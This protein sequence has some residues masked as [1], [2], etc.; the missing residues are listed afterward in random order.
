MRDAP[1]TPG[2]RHAEP[3]R[4]CTA[5]G[6]SIEFTGVTKRY[7]PTTAVEN[8]DLSVRS[9]EFLTLLGPSGSGKST[10]L[11][12]LAGFERPTS[13]DIVVSGRKMNDVPAHRRDQGVV[14]QSYA[15]FPHMSVSENLAY[16]LAARGIAGSERSRLINRALERVR[17]SG[18]D[19]RLPSQLSGGQQQ[20]VA[21]A[22]A[23]VHDPPILLM[24]ESLSALDRNLREEMQIELKDLHEQLGNTIVYVT[25][26]QGEA[27]TMSDRVAVLSQGRLVQLGTPDEVYGSPANAFVAGFIGDANLIPGKALSQAGRLVTVAIAAGQALAVETEETVEAGQELLLMIRPESILLQQMASAPRGS[28]KIGI[29]QGTVKT[30]IFMGD[31]HRY[32]VE[33]LDLKLTTKALYSPRQRKFGVGETVEIIIPSERVRLIDSRSDPVDSRATHSEEKKTR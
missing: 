13:G 29:L 11:M 18:F 22:R 27:L 23:I 20:R 9:G 12:L 25:H 3:Q 26:D 17:M 32:V 14:F 33:S 31:A 21:L 10:L 16:P 7:G 5:K 19:D 30:A 28:E 6:A 4:S 15:L 8:I 24:D 2:R 1:S